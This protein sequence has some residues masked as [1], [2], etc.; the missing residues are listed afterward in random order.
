MEIRE[1]DN[2]PTYE[3]PPVTEVV[4]SVQFEALAA[5]RAWHLGSIQNL[6]SN[7]FP[8]ISEQPPLAPVFETQAKFIQPPLWR[9]E[10]VQYATLARYWFSQEDQNELIQFQNDRLIHNWKKSKTDTVYP[11]Y[12]A[13]L[14][15]FSNEYNILEKFVTE[16]E[17]GSIIPN[18]VELTYVNNIEL[19]KFIHKNNSRIFRIV[20]NSQ[21]A[22]DF[23]DMRFACRY[24]I[25]NNSGEFLGRLHVQCDPVF[26]SAGVPILLFQ[27]TARG[28]PQTGDLNGV[29]EFLN[30]GHAKIVSSFDSLTTDFMHQRWGK[31]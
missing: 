25:K 19:D 22:D 30:I 29:V 20:S 15:K 4:I 6:F 28:R 8:E 31:L 23:E 3:S 11:R 9:I 18:Q 17:F 16:K 2:L 5:I 27:L 12:S 26:D 14:S 7:K 1:S 10:Q 24:M 13:L 21:I